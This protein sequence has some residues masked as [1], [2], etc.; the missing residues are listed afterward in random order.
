MVTPDRRRWDGID[1]NF[2]ALR[3]QPVSG[4]FD[5]PIVGTATLAGLGL[6][7]LVGVGTGAALVEDCHGAGSSSSE[8]GDICTMS[9]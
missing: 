3:W 2:T 9:T 1:L 8:S 6:G 4:S 7:T 5:G